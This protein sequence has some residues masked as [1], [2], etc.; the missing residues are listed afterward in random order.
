MKI[1]VHNLVL[2]L[3]ILRLKDKAAPAGIDKAGSPAALSFV[4]REMQEIL[5]SANLHGDEYCANRDNLKDWIFIIK[6][7]VSNASS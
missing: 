5:D 4:V 3:R 1:C 7:E 6:R 2:K